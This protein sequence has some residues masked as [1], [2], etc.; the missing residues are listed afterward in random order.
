[1]ERGMIGQVSQKPGKGRALP[2][3]A[4]AAG[5]AILAVGPADAQRNQKPPAVRLSKP[6][7]SLL[8]QAQPILQ[9][10]QEQ[11]QAGDKAGAAATART[12][13]PILDQADALPERNADDRHVTSQLRLNAGIL[14]GDN[15]IILKAL[16]D[17][18]ASGKLSPEDQAKYLRNIGSLALQAN[19]T[20]RAMQ[21]FGQLQQMNPNDSQLLVEMAELNRRMKQP[22]KAIE[23][24]RQA[25]AVQEQG[26]AKA[27]ESWYRRALA[28]AYDWLQTGAKTPGPEQQ[29]ARRAVVETSEA[30]VRAYPNGT[31]WRDVLVIYRDGGQFDDQANLDVLRLMRANQAL[32]GERD[33]AEYADTA[34]TRGL[35]G[36]AK[37]VI[38][39]G[40]A[41]G[42]LTANKPFVKEILA[43]VNP[44]VASDRA[45]LPGLER[46]SRSSPNWRTALGTA[47]AHLG[48]GNYAKAA[49]MY[50]LALTK[51]G[52]DAAMIN[53]RLGLAL[54]RS[55]DKA[56]AEAALKAVTGAPR[57]QLARFMLIWLQNQ[58]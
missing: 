22:D 13:I 29:A 18:L 53:T 20:A 4:M 9:K 48:Y 36:E 58:A 2:M 7:Q 50:R 42:A 23:T 24:L 56:G 30:L 25:I 1:M 39:E 35:P 45:A 27:D 21:A 28:I 16:E 54:A 32:A 5:L 14:A 17:G 49:E 19:D 55:G 15:A 37:A 41:K 46:E 10:A 52:A 31:N 43:S 3:M 40:I 6:V 26:G 34:A 51:S 33:Y 38:D 8:A 44:K 47:D 57:D 11:Q 12:A